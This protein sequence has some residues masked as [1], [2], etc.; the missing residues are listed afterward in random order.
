MW[1]RPSCLAGRSLALASLALSFVP[2]R[3]AT[4][5]DPGLL[6]RLPD[7]VVSQIVHRSLRGAIARLGRSET[8]RA[9]LEDFATAD[10]TPLSAVLAARGES[11][12]RY[13]AGLLFLDGASHPHCRCGTVAAFTAP[14]WRVVYV[15]S[16]TFRRHLRGRPDEA[17]TVIIHEALHTLGLG[18]NPPAPRE[19]DERVNARCV[20]GEGP[21]TGSAHAPPRS[22]S[23]RATASRARRK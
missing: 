9:I 14:G 13:A 11:P 2:P 16:A 8:C 21:S 6:V 18:E 4:G 12:A 17:E 20:R 19:I 1:R 15:C 22:S 5:G 23:P 3:G 7:P 10:G